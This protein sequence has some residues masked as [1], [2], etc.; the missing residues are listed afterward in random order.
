MIA[1]FTL[2]EMM[3][4]VS[5]MA[6]SLSSIYKLHA[7]TIRLNAIARFNAVAPLLAQERIAVIDSRPLEDAA[8][9]SGNFEDGF[10][11]YTYNV[12][13]EETP[14]EYLEIEGDLGKNSGLII[15]KI[16]VEIAEGDGQQT[17]KF[18]TY[19]MMVD[20]Q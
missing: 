15:K 5:I 13:I 8:D 7:Q 12:T 6:I 10:G 18:T 16:T 20:N 17:Y 19:R 1:G 14:S 4:A 11:N 9:D 3:V 2:L